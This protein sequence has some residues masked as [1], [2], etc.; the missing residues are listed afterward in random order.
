MPSW[1]IH[2]A[3]ANKL[4]KEL[5]FSNDFII[6]NV[7]PDVLNGYEIENPSSIVDSSITHYRL[8]QAKKKFKI[9]IDYFINNYKEQLT[10]D[11]ITGYLVHLI[12]DSYYNTYTHKHH[13][14]IKND[15]RVTILKDGSILKDENITPWQIKQN[16][17]K[18]FGQ[19]IINDKK[20]G[21]KIDKN[22]MTLEN[23]LKIK[24][25]PLTKEDLDRTIH[26]INK[27]INS[28]NKYNKENYQMFTEEE[29]EELFE[30]CYNYILEYLN[31]IK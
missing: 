24:E 20:L 28:Q 9:D 22:N 7:L 31:K 21:P 11:I 29:L 17:F 3:M 25:C 2:L 26:K 30:N 1:P 16:D 27:L 12:T 5:N 15:Q 14:I 19:K 23:A 6:G 13:I 18:L 10:R 8:N 4:N